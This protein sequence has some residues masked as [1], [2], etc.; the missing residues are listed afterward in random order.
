MAST[1]LEADPQRRWVQASASDLALSMGALE[2]AR[3]PAKHRTPEDEPLS[4]TVRTALRGYRL[5]ASLTEEGGQRPPLVLVS[6]GSGRP[7]T[8]PDFQLLKERFELTDRQSEVALLLA[9]RLSNREIAEALSI[10]P[11]TARHHTEMVLRKLG[12][13][14][15]KSVRARIREEADSGD[16]TG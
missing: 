7:E 15:R 4:R 6:I 8:P 16:G 13:T 14:S 12:I 3:R 10:S 2:L 5:S 11:H 9:R 1:I